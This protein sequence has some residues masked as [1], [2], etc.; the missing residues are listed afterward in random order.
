[1]VG[2]EE[3]GIHL[4]AHLDGVAAI[5]EDGPLVQGEDGHAPGAGKTGEPAQALGVGG[6]IFTLEFILPGNDQPVK[7][8]FPEK[9][10]K[11]GHARFVSHFRSL[12]RCARFRQKEILASCVNLFHIIRIENLGRTI[13]QFAT[14]LGRVPQRLLQQSTTWVFMRCFC[15]SLRPHDNPTEGRSHEYGYC[16]VV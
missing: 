7:P 12:I 14:R 5:D 4:L 16:K 10:P 3:L 2:G 8:L 13:G 11:C 6:H 9:L 1:M 15:I